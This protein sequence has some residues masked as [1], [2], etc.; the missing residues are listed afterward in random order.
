M[1]ELYKTKN[2]QGKNYY[3]ARQTEQYQT[4][5]IEKYNIILLVQNKDQEKKEKQEQQS[6]SKDNLD[7]LIEKIENQFE[8][9][10][11]KKIIS[12][13]EKVKKIK[14]KKYIFQEDYKNPEKDDKIIY[15]PEFLKNKEKLD[16]KE[17][18]NR[19]P[20]SGARIIYVSQ[21]SLPSGPGYKVLGM[22]DPSKHT[23]YIS[24]DLPEY[25]KRFVYHHEVAH[26]LGIRDET[27]ADNYAAQQV[28]YH[29][30]RA[31]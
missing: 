5:Y 24:Q 25:Q 10:G 30:R 7:S 27:F 23:I 12:L 8:E 21:S 4:I 26:A 2:K 19:D 31:A 9:I 28:G 16:V 29:L 14:D 3:G 20:K 22:Y 1:P 17:F 15:Y 6:D 18:L 11:N 13:E